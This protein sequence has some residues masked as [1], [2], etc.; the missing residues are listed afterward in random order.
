MKKISF[1]NEK[2]QIAA[3]NL[4]KLLADL[5]I[6]SATSINVEALADS[7][8]HILGSAS[9]RHHTIHHLPHLSELTAAE[10]AEGVNE[11]QLAREDLAI[12]RAVAGTARDFVSDDGPAPQ[13][14]VG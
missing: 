2:E 4:L 10:K 9:M 12:Q 3:D 11:L 5:T 13:P 8:Q 7:Y 1:L 14:V 6:E